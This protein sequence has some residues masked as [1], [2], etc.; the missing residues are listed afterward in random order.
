MVEGKRQRKGKEI[1]DLLQKQ[2]IFFCFVRPW[3]EANLVE[4]IMEIIFGG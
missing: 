2:L 3:K 4:V 1:F